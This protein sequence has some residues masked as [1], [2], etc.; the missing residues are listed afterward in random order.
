MALL[1][2]L[3]GCGNKLSGPDFEHQENKVIVLSNDIRIDYEMP[4]DMSSMLGFSEKQKKQPKSINIDDINSLNFETKGWRTTNNLDVGMWEYYRGK[5]NVEKNIAAELSIRIDIHKINDGNTT[6][7]KSYL[8]ATY[9]EYLNGT[10]GINTK[11]RKDFAEYS[12]D[13][14]TKWLVEMPEFKETNINNADFI[15]WH[16]YGEVRGRHL[17]Y[18]V[19]PIDDTH[20]LTIRI[21]YSYSA[22]SDEEL[23]E[24]EVLLPEDIEKL[25]Q[26]IKITRL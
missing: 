4:G 19:T 18:Y 14:L 12:D 20:Y 13:E 15:S 11:T 16:V 2:T 25:V 10:N 26:Q 21:R 9:E 22:L 7:L 1:S 3:F 5:K 23:S 8:K 17:Q 24:L 6:S